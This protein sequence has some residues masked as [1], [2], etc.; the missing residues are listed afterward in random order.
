MTSMLPSPDIINYLVLD[1]LVI[2]YTRTTSDRIV[3]EAGEMKDKRST[4][5][6]DLRKEHE[7]LEATQIRRRL[8]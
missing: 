1:V 4:I 3:L 2:L 7:A 8:T 6:A 5:D